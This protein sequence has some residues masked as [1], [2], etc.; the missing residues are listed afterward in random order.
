[1]HSLWSDGSS[2]IA[3]MAN[4]AFELNYEYIAITDHA[5]G[6]KIAGGINEAQLREQAAEIKSVNCSLGASRHKLRVLR[7]TELNL[8]PAGDGDMGVIAEAQGR[9]DRTLSEWK[10]PMT[11]SSSLRASSIAL[12]SETAYGTSWVRAE[13]RRL[14]SHCAAAGM[15]K[16]N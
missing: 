16:W 9:S 3:D 14:A 8:N 13:R 12:S 1:M 5:K 7:S 11:R 15:G 10:Q 4:A 6:L 2:S